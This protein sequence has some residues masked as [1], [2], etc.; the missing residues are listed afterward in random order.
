MTHI[1][2]VINLII[3]VFSVNFAANIDNTSV[4]GAGK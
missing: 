3:S 4:A 1:Y 2:S